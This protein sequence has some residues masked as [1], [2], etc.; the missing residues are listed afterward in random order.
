MLSIVYCF[1]KM[2]LKLQN[3]FVINREVM[4]NER[5]KKSEKKLDG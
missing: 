2:G 3:R 5:D 4:A 1:L